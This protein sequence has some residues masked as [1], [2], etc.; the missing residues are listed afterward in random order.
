MP[1]SAETRAMA[2][3]VRAE[4]MG[5]LRGAAPVAPLIDYNIP[6]SLG[7]RTP[8]FAPGIVSGTD[9]AG[10]PYLPADLAPE[11]RTPYLPD[12]LSSDPGLPPA[13]L[14]EALNG[15]EVTPPP[16]PPL[17]FGPGGVVISG[18][19]DTAE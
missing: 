12:D 19:P 14:D 9:V 3:V 6:Y 5:A 7:T 8:G 10:T 13:F 15:G 11:P 16:P 17:R 2:D 4:Q 1:A 18:G